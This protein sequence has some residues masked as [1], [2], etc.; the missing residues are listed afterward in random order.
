MP[1]ATLRFYEELNEYLPPERHKRAFEVC[2]GGRLSVGDIIE[3]QGIPEDEV[4]LVLVNGQSVAFD[5][6]LRDGDRVSV[7][8]VFERFNVEGV[9][10][11][12]ERPLRR[13]KFM[14]EKDL[15]KAAERLHAMGF[16]VYCEADLGIDDA[17]EISRK[18]KRILLTTR[19]EVGKSG[20]VD[21]VVYVAPGTVEDQVRGI[22]EDLHVQLR[23]N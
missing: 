2:F 12:R 6:V 20:K 1:K 21:R 23:L 5:H 22:L 16:D 18:E 4:D 3:E 8:P 13:L 17:M 9:S 7:Y 10:R 14:A 15:K 11:L 19:E